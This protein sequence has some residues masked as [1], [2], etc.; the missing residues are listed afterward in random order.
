[1]RLGVVGG[2]FDPVHLGH[3]AVARAALDCVPLDRV[4]LVPAAV[5]PHRREAVASAQD[6]LEMCRL[7]IAGDSRLEVSDREVRRPGP[8][9]TVD[10]LAELARERPGDQL[11]LVLG[12]DAAREIR[13][14]REPDR[15][16]G[17][18]VLVVVTRPG[19]PAPG[20]V[21]LS[22]AGLDGARTLLCDAATPSVQATAIRELVAAR[23]PLDG[24][25]APPVADYIRLHGLY[26]RA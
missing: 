11:Y 20:P 23:A 26:S 17:L 12:W 6:R 10:T 4:L 25:L 24:M 18:A 14:W 13:T 1:M 22:A 16:L 19:L 2:T 21:D 8:S 5:P 15:V 3:L 7:A 9:F